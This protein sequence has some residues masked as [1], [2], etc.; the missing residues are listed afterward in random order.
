MNG[1]QGTSM[2]KHLSDSNSFEHL[3]NEMCASSLLTQL[4]IKMLDEQY[5]SVAG[6]RKVSV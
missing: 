2:I 4:L 6:P 1:G 3:L 5:L